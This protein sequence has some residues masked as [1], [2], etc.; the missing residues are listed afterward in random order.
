MGT[1][2]CMWY[3]DLR[4]VKIPIHIK[5]NDGNDD[6]KENSVLLSFLNPLISQVLD[7]RVICTQHCA[8][9]WGHSCGKYWR[10]LG[11]RELAE[12]S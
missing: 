11:L 5:Y 7:E 8:R 6:D 10:D 3:T 4:I 2:A 12:V 9:I 1:K